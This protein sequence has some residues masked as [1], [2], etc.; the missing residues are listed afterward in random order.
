MKSVAEIADLVEIQTWAADKP[1][2]ISGLKEDL[3]AQMQN[4]VDDYEPEH[5]AQEI[6]DALAARSRTLDDAYP[7]SFD[8]YTLR[9]RA[10][11]ANGSSYLFCLGLSLLK[12]ENVKPHIRN[13]EFETLVMRAAQKYF[14]G[15]AVRIGAPWKTAAVPNYLTLLK[16]VSDL[17]P[18][19]G[20]PTRT[21]A[22]H[23]GD[24]GWDVVIVKNFG[25]RKFPRLVALGNCATGRTDWRK[26]G[27]ETL[28]TYFWS[29]FSHAHRSV[30]ITFLAAPFVMDENDRL[31]K[32]DSTTLTFDRLRICEHAIEVNQ[33]SQ[34][35]LEANKDHLLALPLT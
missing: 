33:Q 26:K 28:P 6:F 12:P 21:K 24:G 15:Q 10:Q 20:S 34:D 25:D 2:T 16:S 27:A 5:H 35:W 32:S 13:V 7:F 19:L 4:G 1:C 31:R 17:I 23:G 22:P 14:G 11:A 8:G 3:E 29:F 30:C 9:A 18:E